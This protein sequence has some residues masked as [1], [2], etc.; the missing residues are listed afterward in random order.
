MDVSR[1]TSTLIRIR[2]ENPP[3]DTR[4]VI[5]FIRSYL[6]E[7]GVKNEAIE[8]EKGRWNLVSFNAPKGLLA[9]GHVDVVPASEQGWSRDRFS[10][11]IDEGRVWGR[12]SSDM[13]GGCAAILSALEILIHEQ[14]EPAVNL[15]FVCDEETG[16][17]SGIRHL[18]AQHRI[19]PCDCL[20]AE[21]TPPL[22]PSVGQ[23][24]LCRLE[25]SFQG[26]PG[27]ASLHPLVGRSA[28]MDA[29][30]FIEH[31][32]ELHKRKYEVGGEIG[33]LIDRSAEVL[34][35]VFDIDHVQEVLTRITFN[36]G[37]IRGGEKVNIVAQHCRLELDLRIPWG[38][39]GEAL[40]AE[41]RRSIPHG[42]V[43]IV[44]YS[45]PNMTSPD[46]TLVQIL[47]SEIGRVYGQVPQPIV[48]WAATDAKFLR[49]A[50]CNAV[51]YGPGD[52]TTLHGI[53]ESVPICSL[54]N[55]VKVYSGVMRRYSERTT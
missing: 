51:E 18:I 2:S 42:N 5:G 10:G 49:K 17:K 50:G 23:K 15:A 11:E 31:L 32:Q 3:G 54:E 41:I 14:I 45:A 35:S 29:V 16:G 43:R 24:G 46:A 20:V 30:S 53:D 12:G 6:D 38:C 7:L 34:A 40:I 21:P 9:C 22:S 36:P 39:E 25:L 44:D 8:G 26:L 55:A 19:P 27:H 33:T 4:D 1:L 28:I 47:C 52:L 13:K 48:Q 37:V